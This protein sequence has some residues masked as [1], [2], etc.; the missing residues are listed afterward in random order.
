MASSITATSST[1]R[2]IDFCT[3]RIITKIAAM[4]IRLTT[5]KSWSVQAIRS[6]VH[7]A[8]PIS[9]PPSSYFFRIP[10]SVSICAFTSSDEIT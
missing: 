4:E 8:S 9:I 5:V 1:G 6:F 7:D 2:L 10:F 3:S